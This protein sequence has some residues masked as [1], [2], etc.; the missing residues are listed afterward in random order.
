MDT[1]KKFIRITDTLTQEDFNGYSDTILSNMTGSESTL[2]K[3]H[4][5]SKALAACMYQKYLDG[6]VA[7]Y[8]DKDGNAAGVMGAYLGDLWWIKGNVL[9]E[10]FIISLAKEPNGFLSFAIDVLDLLAKYNNCVLICTGSSMMMQDKVVWNS[11]RKHGYENLGESF[12][13]EVTE[14]DFAV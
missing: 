1:K 13:K 7:V 14:H 11:Y 8:M 12:L 2:F 3:H 5:S 10:D 4:K 9:V 6:T